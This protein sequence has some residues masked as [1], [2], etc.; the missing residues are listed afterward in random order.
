MLIYINESHPLH[1][2]HCGTFYVKLN[3]LIKAYNLPKKNVPTIAFNIIKEKYPNLPYTF[4]ANTLF[5][6]FDRIQCLDLNR[7]QIYDLVHCLN[8]FLEKYFNKSIDQ[9]FNVVDEAVPLFE[10]TVRQCVFGVLNRDIEFVQIDNNSY[11]FKAI[12]VARAASISC[13]HNVNKYVDDNNMVLWQDLKR[14]LN[15]NSVFNKWKNNTVFL[16]RAGLKQLLY[17]R[18]KSELYASINLDL[19]N[20]NLQTAY[21]KHKY[22][23]FKKTLKAVGCSV[24][25][26]FDKLHYIV[27]DGVVWFKLNQ[28][29]KYFDIPKQ[30]PDYNI[31]TWYTLSKRLKSNITWKLNT[32]MISDMGVYKLLIIKNEIIAEEFYHKRLHELRSTGSPL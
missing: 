28:I 8:E 24:G 5:I 31:I 11:Y 3:Q 15:Q 1:V 29:C 21:R 23:Y 4:H 13:S 12:D 9:N 2:I 30:Y 18:G 19:E 14:Y 27:I 7:V 26:L 25:I 22:R 32:I 20:Q 10:P 6:T 17:A 16:K